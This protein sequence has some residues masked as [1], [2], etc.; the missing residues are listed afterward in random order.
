MKM[1]MMNRMS[2]VWSW[3]KISCSIIGDDAFCKESWPQIGIFKEAVPIN[4]F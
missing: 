1:V 2:I 3:K 4:R